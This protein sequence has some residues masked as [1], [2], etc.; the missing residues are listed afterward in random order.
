V[1]K[2][3]SFKL[4]SHIVEKMNYEQREK[5]LNEK[6]E[7]IQKDIRKLK[8]RFS[9]ARIS[10][11]ERLQITLALCNLEDTLTQINRE[12]RLVWFI[13]QSQIIA[14]SSNSSQSSSS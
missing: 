3:L 14:T 4:V 10:A 11:W 5:E 9:K 7:A 6:Y 2:N 13:K 1:S 12:M 8:A